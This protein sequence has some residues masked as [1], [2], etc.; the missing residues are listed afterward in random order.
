MTMSTNQF[1]IIKSFFLCFLKRSGIITISWKKFNLWVASKY[2]NEK[3]V[4]KIRTWKSYPQSLCWWLLL[5]LWH[6]ESL[7]VTSFGVLRVLSRIDLHQWWCRALFRLCQRT[8]V[9]Q[10]TCV[11]CLPGL[12]PMRLGLRIPMSLMHCTHKKDRKFHFRMFWFR[13]Q[14]SYCVLY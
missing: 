13:E 8:R 3:D 14:Q 4:K 2:I 9:A 5:L 6:F 1:L 11:W 10:E 7:G 12:Q